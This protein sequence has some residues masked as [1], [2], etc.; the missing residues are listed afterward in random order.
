MN[1]TKIEWCDYTVNPVKGLCPMACPYCYARRMYKRYHWDETTRYDR[2]WGKGILSLKKPARIF[3]GS[4]CELF[5]SWVE[6]AW[7][8]EIF[9]SV[10]SQHTFIFLTKQPQNLAKWSPFPKNCWVG[11]S[12]TDFRSFALGTAHL[13]PVQAT[14][15]FISAEPL[16]HSFCGPEV[17]E[18]RLRIA[19][20]SWAIIGQQ[21]PVSKKTEPKAE[22]IHDI[23]KAADNAGI[24]VF[25]KNNLYSIFGPSKRLRQ[26]FPT[27]SQNTTEERR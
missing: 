11:V 17:V 18:E 24:P 3:V 7:L 23:V 19:H 25:E 5:G 13:A 9:A 12:A 10:T 21:T 14:V 20:V 8:S 15:K 22:W 6:D 26:E 16:L 4:T 27:I 1:R 2:E